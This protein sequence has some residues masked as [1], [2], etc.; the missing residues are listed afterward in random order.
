VTNFGDM[1]TEAELV[2]TQ[3]AATRDMNAT[4]SGCGLAGLLPPRDSRI[5]AATGAPW[6]EVQGQA[7]CLTVSGSRNQ[8]RTGF[9]RHPRFCDRS[10]GGR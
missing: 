4:C 6:G 8:G 10:G 3:L 9:H 1:V 2:L 5:T 7:G